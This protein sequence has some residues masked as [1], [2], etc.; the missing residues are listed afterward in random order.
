[1]K[2]W[3]NVKV[4]FTKQFT[5]G[6]LKRVTEPYLVS[7]MS[8]SDAEAIIYQEVG[9]LIKGEFMVKKI[10]R[11]DVADIFHYEDCETWWS[12]KVSY[13]TEDA[14]S[15]KEKRVLNTFLVSAQNP[16]E[17]TDRVMESLKGLMATFEVVKVEKS[18]IVE[19]ITA[20]LREEKSKE[21]TPKTLENV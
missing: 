11:F 21:V 7:A 17:A 2:Q 13:T 5:D 18:P 12:T 10:D 16:K 20:Q 4:K 14:D 8:F 3:W 1:M 15:G 19:V 6:T 9:E